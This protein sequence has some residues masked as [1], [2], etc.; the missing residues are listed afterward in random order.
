MWILRDVLYMSTVRHPWQTFS[1][2]CL[3]SFIKYFKCNSS[4][5]NTVSVI[6]HHC[7]HYA[8]L[9]T[10]TCHHFHF[11]LTVLQMDPRLPG[12]LRGQAGKVHARGSERA[13]RWPIR[14]CNTEQGRCNTWNP[15]WQY[16]GSPATQLSTYAQQWEWEG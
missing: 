1:E 8:M 11:T 2:A 7:R 5:S 14:T 3:R 10:A 6:S 15:I 12:C 4:E 13:F 9:H 16:P